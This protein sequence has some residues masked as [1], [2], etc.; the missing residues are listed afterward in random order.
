MVASSSLQVEDLPAPNLV[1]T[2]DGWLVMGQALISITLS[3]EFTIDGSQ[4][5]V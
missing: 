5:L 2:L 4:F 3:L 1:K